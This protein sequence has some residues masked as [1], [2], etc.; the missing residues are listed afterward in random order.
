MLLTVDKLF[1][2]VPSTNFLLIDPVEERI[3]CNK[4][5]WLE[6]QISPDSNSKSGK[7]FYISLE[8][9]KNLKK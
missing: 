9:D 6:L 3:N 5:E 8:C 4:E 1:I 7:S 2:E